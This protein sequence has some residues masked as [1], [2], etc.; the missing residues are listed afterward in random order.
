VAKA[1]AATELVGGYEAIS[2]AIKTHLP[3]DRRIF[4]SNISTG[5]SSY[6][7]ITGGHDHDAI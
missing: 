1:N 5:T 7:E 4:S 3:V 2:P 6:H